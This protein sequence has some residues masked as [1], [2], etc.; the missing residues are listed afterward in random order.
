MKSSI[1]REYSSS[2]LIAQ[3]VESRLKSFQFQPDDPFCE[4][5]VL[6]VV[7]LEEMKALKDEQLYQKII[8]LY[9][10]DSRELV[11]E[12]GKVIQSSGAYIL[13]LASLAMILSFLVGFI[14]GLSIK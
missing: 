9:Q 5:N 12:L 6:I 3:A 14:F 2:E 13:G 11:K 4:Y 1:I 7:L 10:K 8:G